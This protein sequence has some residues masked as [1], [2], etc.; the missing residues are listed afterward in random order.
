MAHLHDN[1]GD[2]KLISIVTPQVLSLRDSSESQRKMW[3][4]FQLKR[5]QFNS[6]IAL[7]F[8]LFLQVTVEKTGHLRHHSELLNNRN[9]FQWDTVVFVTSFTALEHDV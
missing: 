8:L 4:S 3:Q 1:S 7:V 9:N 6:N 5:K 2:G